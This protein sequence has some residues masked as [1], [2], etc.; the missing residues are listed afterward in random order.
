MKALLIAVSTLVLLSA[1][2]CS[3]I[4]NGKKQV[5]TIN[6]NVTEADVTVNGKPVGKTPFTGEIERASKALVQVSKEG[7]ETKI[8]TMDTSFEPIFWGNILCGGGIGSTT[9]GVS[10]AMY[11]YAPST[12]QVDMTKK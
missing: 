10:G 5:V 3:T 6:S 8:I 2:G 4:V 1:T 7:F 11:K 12:I 9:D